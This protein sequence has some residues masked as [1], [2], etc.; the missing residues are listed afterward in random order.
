MKFD[1]NDKYIKIGLVVTL[2]LIAAYAGCSLLGYIP[3]ALEHVFNF[4]DYIISL[5]TPI[6]IAFIIAYLLLIPTRAI[7]NFLLSRKHLKLKNRTLCRAISVTITYVTVIGIMVATVI[8]IYYMIGGQISKSTTVKHIY[9]TIISYFNNDTLSADYIQKQL[10]KMN[11]P[12]MD[13]ISSKM[14][15]IATFLSSAISKFISFAFG[16]LLSLGGNIFNILISIILSIYFIMSYEYFN[17]FM[18]KVFYVIFRNSNTG[19]SIRKYLS[20]INETFTS[21]IRGQLI[22]AFIVAVLSTIALYIVDIDYPIV[23]GIICGITNLVPY[24]GPLVG[25][26]L[27]GLIGLLSGDFLTCVWAVVAM[28][29]VQQID[30]NIICPRVVGNIVGLPGAFVIIAIL[31][32]GSYAG[33]IGMLLAVPVA[34]SLKT[35]IGEWFDNH[36]SGFEAHYQSVVSDY[37]LRQSQK[38]EDHMQMKQEKRN[39]NKILKKFHKKD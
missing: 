29:V 25:T 2:S 8:G 31:I 28:Q 12:F 6:I 35:I 27:A 23:I 22:E 17:K 37:D 14:G 11:L 39:N 5:S 15:T 36:F 20:I 16:T 7:E 24:V 1:K 30:A 4:I 26:V 3:K 33:L 34:A 18:N 21:Y 19:K 9:D 10:T 38:K 13:I 32:G